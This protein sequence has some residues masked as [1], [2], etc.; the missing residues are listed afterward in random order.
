MAEHLPPGRAG[1]LWLVERIGTA[2]RG[3]ELLRQKRQVLRREQ[4]RLS[5][6]AEQTGAAWASAA[7]HAERWSSRACALGGSTA[8][9]LAAGDVAGRGTVSISWRNTMGTRHPDEARCE[10]PALTPAAAASSN[11]AIAPAAAAHGRALRAA[12]EHAV[13]S[14]ALRE[15]EIE[16]A[17][18]QRRLRAIEHHRLPALQRQLHDLVLRLD[19]LER[20]ER[21]IARWAKRRGGGVLR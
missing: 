15:V 17:S 10:L 7:D 13:A 19:E 8:V 18:T 20:E 5:L 1:R 9:R 4:R 2:T 21:L 14:A 6:M 12:A 3:V 16:L 11:A